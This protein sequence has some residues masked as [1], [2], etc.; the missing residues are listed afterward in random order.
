M[1]RSVTLP[2]FHPDRSSALQYQ[3]SD[4]TYKTEDLSVM[5][6]KIVRSPSNIN[7]HLFLSTLVEYLQDHFQLPPRLPMVYEAKTIEDSK[8]VVQ[9][10]S[11]L[12][13]SSDQTCLEVQVVAVFPE[14]QSTTTNLAMVV[15]GKRPQTGK[16]LPPLLRNLFEDSEKQI[17]KALDRGLEKYMS[18]KISFGSTKSNSYLEGRQSILA[19]ILGNDDDKSQQ[20]STPKPGFTDAE[21]VSKRQQATVQRTLEVKKSTASSSSSTNSRAN[22][23][24]LDFAVQQ[25]KLAAERN[26]KRTG[27]G[28]HAVDAAK[29]AAEKMR[30]K[31][32]RSTSLPEDTYESGLIRIPEEEDNEPERLDGDKASPIGMDVLSYRPAS[33][34]RSATGKPRAFMQT[35]SRPADYLKDQAKSSAIEESSLNEPMARN[36][37]LNIRQDAGGDAVFSDQDL[38]NDPNDIT[39]PQQK[40]MIKAAQDALLEMSE[41]GEE[42]TPEELLNQV[43]KFGDEQDNESTLGAGFVSGA[44]EKAKDLLR[45]QRQ[46][47]EDRLMSDVADKAA[48]EVRT[49]TA[50]TINIKTMTIEEELRRMFEAGENIA[51]GRLS[52][53]ETSGAFSEEENMENKNE[54]DNLIAL[55]NSI[56]SHAR[57]LDDELAELEIRINKSPDEELDGP[58]K[59]PLFDIFSGPEVYNPNVDPETAVNWPGASPGTGTIRLP[60]ELDEALRQAQFASEVLQ[61]MKEV[62]E[63]LLDGTSLTTYFVG[64]RQLTDKQVQNMRTLMA[65]AVDIGLIDNPLLKM[66]ESSQLQMLL[67]ELWD[68]PEE[69]HNEITSNYKDLLLSD[70]FVTLVKERLALMADRDLEAMRRGDDS[71]ETTSSRERQLLGGLVVA[72]QLLLKEARA[73]GAQLEAQQLEVIRSI[74]KIA[75][76]PKHNTE[77]ETA[78]ALTDGVREMRPLF[79][80]AFVAYLKYAVAEEEA[81]LARAGLLD[82]PEHNQWLHVL[83]IVQQGVYAEL[84]RGINRY[85]DHIGYV[86][87]METAVERRLLLKQLID[88]MPS[89]DVRPFVQV[90]DNI[91]GSLG[92]SVRGNFAGANV[93]GDMTNKLLQL[94]RDMKELLPEERIA[95]M[96]RDADEWARRQREK[97]MESRSRTQ[98]LLEAARETEHLDEEVESLARRGEV[99]SFD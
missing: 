60:K 56:S 5:Y 39:D 31:S 48:V 83:K 30:E 71:I 27:S 52:K 59:A 95:L 63:E 28:N 75:M 18:G 98:K 38:V 17:L 90:V 53:I 15:V 26:A 42:L 54:V 74:C 13:P 36:L 29:R 20:Q 8:S 55:E 61:K 96:S 10:D 92:D 85:I 22:P 51:D 7:S 41:Q 16:S 64:N 87:R 66:K 45:E 25:A 88:V 91:V 1:L 80:D 73:L 97:L 99:D 94:S 19:E 11:S 46:R 69:R 40:E 62:K 24:G 89:L 34:D 65:E 6:Q 82:D 44:F 35:I 93:L 76:D 49:R 33:L 86:L 78:Q 58:L 68:Q 2:S 32:A 84:A 43:M 12:S 37:N 14:D 3:A 57:I 81:K 50:E 47:R 79:D 67:D 9:W 70:N 77:E 72:A 23:P 21:I 4:G